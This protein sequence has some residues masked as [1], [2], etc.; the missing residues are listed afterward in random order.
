[1]S[2]LLICETT[3]VESYVAAFDSFHSV[4]FDNTVNFADCVAVFVP[5]EV[6]EFD[7]THDVSELLP[8]EAMKLLRHDIPTS[9]NV[10]CFI[11]Y[12]LW[13]MIIICV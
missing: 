4:P 3:V 8:H 2:D 6:V 11:I 13:C 12:A 1:M 10:Y 7:G 5:D 9:G